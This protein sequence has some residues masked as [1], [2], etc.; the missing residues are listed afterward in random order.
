MEEMGSIFLSIGVMFCFCMVALLLYQIVRMIKPVVD[1]EWKY[2]L[3]EENVLDRVALKRGID[4][5]KAGIERIYS[6]VLE[7]NNANIR[8]LPKTGLKMI[9]IAREL[10]ICGKKYIIW[11]KKK[12]DKLKSSQK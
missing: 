4:L 10:N 3:L 9:G 1:K 5:K 11:Y 8:S 7:W 2:E 6:E 12:Y